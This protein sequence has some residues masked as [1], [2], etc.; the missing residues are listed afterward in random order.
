MSRLQRKLFSMSRFQKKLFSMS[1]LQ[2]VDKLSVKDSIPGGNKKK[3]KFQQNECYSL[4]QQ[5][6]LM[7]QNDLTV[8]VLHENPEG[9]QQNRNPLYN[10]LLLLLFIYLQTVKPGPQPLS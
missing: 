6:I 4:L 7:V 10:K 8:D 9:L 1:R 5:E 3:R 2:S